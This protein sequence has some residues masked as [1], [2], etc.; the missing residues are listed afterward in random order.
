MYR[1][2]FSPAGLLNATSVSR[3]AASQLSELQRANLLRQFLTSDHI[4]P[5][6][7]YIQF[8][9]LDRIARKV[10]SCAIDRTYVPRGHQAKYGLR[11]EIDAANLPQSER[12]RP[13]FA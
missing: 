3:M 8:F 4:S 12:H 10:C 2:F 11:L 1:S 5:C 6:Y 9:I 13:H 7:L